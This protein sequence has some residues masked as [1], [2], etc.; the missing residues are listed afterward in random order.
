MRGFAPVEEQLSE[1]HLLRCLHKYNQHVHLGATMD[2]LCELSR[3]PGP[4]GRPTGKGKSHAMMLALTAL[5]ACQVYQLR[6]PPLSRTAL[7]PVP[8]VSDQGRSVVS[9]HTCRA[10]IEAMRAIASR[11]KPWPALTGKKSQVLNQTWTSADKMMVDDKRWT[12][13]SC[14]GPVQELEEWPG[15]LQGG[16]RSMVNNSVPERVVISGLRPGPKRMLVRRGEQTLKVS[17]EPGTTMHLEN[18][19]LHCLYPKLSGAM[20]QSAS[21]VPQWL[22]AMRGHPVP[23]ENRADEIG[24]DILRVVADSAV[25]RQ[26]LQKSVTDWKEL[27]DP[28]AGTK[29][30]W[31]KGPQ[32]TPIEKPDKP[33]PRAHETS[34]MYMNWFGH[35]PKTVL[36]S[37]NR[38]GREAEQEKD[39]GRYGGYDATDYG[40]LPIEHQG[41]LRAALLRGEFHPTLDGVLLELG[42]RLKA[43]FSE[44]RDK[45]DAATPW[46]LL[47]PRQLMAL[48]SIMARAGDPELEELLARRLVFNEVYAGL[49]GR[50]ARTADNT[51]AGSYVVDHNMVAVLHPSVGVLPGAGLNGEDVVQPKRYSVYIHV[52]LE[53]VNAEAKWRG[54]LPQPRG[55][56]RHVLE[57][58]SYILYKSLIEM[59]AYQADSLMARPPKDLSVEA[60]LLMG[61][62]ASFRPG[63]FTNLIRL[64]CAVES[65][66]GQFL[67]EN[68]AFAGRD[69]GA[70]GNYNVL[71][72]SSARALGKHPEYMILS[73]LGLAMVANR[74]PSESVMEALMENAKQAGTDKASD[75]AVLDR[76]MH[77]LVVGQGYYGASQ[78]NP[79]MSFE[80]QA[81]AAV[82][83][84]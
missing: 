84:P 13:G 66:Q 1:L 47:E 54:W 49:I 41:R 17:T 29:V 24:L 36:T 16:S 42:G 52:S 78:T 32:R 57:D 40:K 37:A 80:G 69:A 12:A 48:R 10:Y 5:M 67:S 81:A 82:R 70:A 44:G 25:A 15:L 35:Q 55:F 73:A 31:T 28:P 6:M 64:G 53:S 58:G 11:T 45:K 33:A 63:I 27:E 51:A 21:E 56:S 4:D 60:A 65:R 19:L 39:C 14:M 8:A 71:V 79:S 3:C 61:R 34:A 50:L 20:G 46:P 9:E 23:M 22:L 59:K 26:T 68:I 72:G 74:D 75:K 43:I 18:M 76:E 2:A 83:P 30:D 38:A 77:K 7:P 62:G